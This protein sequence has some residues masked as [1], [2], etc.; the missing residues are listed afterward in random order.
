MIILKR[1]E[2]E[3]PVKPKAKDGKILFDKK[4]N[5]YNYIMS[6]IEWSGP[7]CAGFPNYTEKDFSLKSRSYS[8]RGETSGTYFCVRY[9]NSYGYGT[10]DD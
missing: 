5:R 10:C 4:N 1:I 2:K 7:I 3:I 6:G 8:M 9:W